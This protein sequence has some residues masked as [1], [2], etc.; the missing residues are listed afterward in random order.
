MNHIFI[1]YSRKNEAVVDAFTQ[2][3][4]DKG[5]SIWQDKSGAGTGIPFSTK[6][7]DVITEALY[8]ASAAI[9]FRSEYWD[10]SVNCANEFDLIK[11][12][13]IPYLELNPDE[14]EKDPE[15]AIEKVRLFCT[16]QVN[17]EKN[18]NRTQLFS[19]A[20]EL[21]T[22]VDPYQLV[23][24]TRGFNDTMDYLI[25]DLGSLSTQMKSE[26]YKQLNP[27]MYPYMEQ[28]I[29]FARNSTI[30][31][32]GGIVLG[33]LLA[34]ASA[35][36]AIAGVIAIGSGTQENTNVYNGQAVSGQIAELREIDP[37]LAISKAVN[38]NTDYLQVT[39]FFTLNM[40]AVR[41]QNVNLPASVAK[42][43][44]DLYNS[45]LAK[46]P[47]LTGSLYRAEP[48]D[49]SGSMQITR[50][51]NGLTW[52]I[53]TPGT[54]N[55]FSWS[56]DGRYLA[57]ASGSKVYVYDPSGYGN[58][59]SLAENYEKINSLRFM[60]IDGS[61][62]IT[63]ITERGTALLWEN[64]I[65]PGSVERQGINYGVFL[66]NQDV[67]TAVFVD[68]N[69]LIINRDHEL[70]TINIAV[71]GVLLPA[72]L[73]VTDNGRTAAM[74]YEKDGTYGVTCINL[75]NG[76]TELSIASDYRLTGLAF[77]ADGNSL[78]ASAFGCT[79]AKIDLDS[80]AITY[81][82][83]PLY[84]WNIA[85]WGQNFVLTD[86]YGQYTVID[87]TMTILTDFYRTNL[88]FMPCFTME[89]AQKKGYMF[90]VNR[91]GASTVFC[92]RVNLNNPAK[93]LFFVPETERIDA[94]TA[95]A[96]SADE[97]YVAFGYPDGLVRVYETEHMYL[98][99]ELQTQGNSVSAL[100]FSSD[101]SGLY[102]LS[103]SGDIQTLELPHYYQNSNLA[104]MQANWQ[105]ITN[106]L[107]DKYNTYADALPTD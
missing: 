7:F 52:T 65:K 54:V 88:A 11:K 68:G 4:K 32:V 40:N 24:H 58:P 91:G 13:A 96:V 14:V 6:W 43:D 84:L 102:V 53:N 45:V 101:G 23:E 89:L 57:F 56:D 104:A 47:V 78:Y 63:A 66:Q 86:Y 10:K 93:N 35:V 3:L 59:I 71:E 107:A 55:C 46:K 33:A 9:I 16:Q 87:E 18:S 36:M 38:M 30:R 49:D 98:T 77:N 80:G 41:L 5:Y 26:N 64:P 81:G 85:R 83:L 105:I 92:E 31:R 50:L 2:L 15:A 12:C 19:A 99:A 79:A 62:Y 37:L 1:S 69:D 76:I 75:E 48:Q 97:G 106:T 74:I 67:P 34:I 21:K 25:V 8:L 90:T 17:N 44:S 70:K 42:K 51:T 82:D 73:A 28:Y 20:Y 94:N 95:V 39:S 100:R 103:E 29:K 72:S 61:T 60:D 22:N 27:E